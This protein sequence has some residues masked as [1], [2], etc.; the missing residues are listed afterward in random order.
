[1]VSKSTKEF[2]KT[3]DQSSD[4]PWLDNPP[5]LKFVNFVETHEYQDDRAAVIEDAHDHSDLTPHS[6]ELFCPEELLIPGV[7][8]MCLCAVHH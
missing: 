5:T 3:L 4:L 1:M 8:M 7:E 6:P 2:G